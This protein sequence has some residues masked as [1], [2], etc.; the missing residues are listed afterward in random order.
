[1]KL[2]LQNRRKRPKQSFSQHRHTGRRLT[3]HH[4]SYGALAAV[5]VLAGLLMAMISH[6]VHAESTIVVR[7]DIATTA[8]IIT[9]PLAG[10]HFVAKQ[11][12]VSGTCQP[13]FGVVVFKNNIIAGASVCQNDGT[14]DLAIDLLVGL[15]SLSVQH[16]R[17][18]PVSP[19]SGTLEVY[20][21][22]PTPSK[23]SLPGEATL[24]NPDEQFLIT[25]DTAYQGIENG[26]ILEWLTALRGGLAPYAIS[27]DWGDGTVELMSRG[28]GGPFSLRHKYKRSGAYTIIIIGKDSAGQSAQI[29]L[30][31]LVR[32][33]GSL[34]IVASTDNGRVNRPSLDILWGLY[35]VSV[36]ILLAFWFGTRYELAYIKH[37]LKG[38]S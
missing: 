27:W 3:H 23:V 18:G 30:V 7:A 25:A 4:T 8:P 9:I 20:Y 1:M 29:Q 10:R 38:Q 19:M 12:R 6:S 5:M 26:Q 24:L 22:P 37:H 31:A 17:P 13:G 14:F 15:N 2:R 33:S 32:G 16:Y 34:A 11:V 35:V 36:V 21:D 28:Q